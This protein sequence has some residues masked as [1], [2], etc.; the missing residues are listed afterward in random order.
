MQDHTANLT[1]LLS[2]K[3][4]AVVGG[5]AWCAAII[6]AA[7]QI[8]FEGTITPVHPKAS[9]VAGLPALRSVAEIAHPI[10]AAF[11]GVNRHATIEVVGQLRAA[12]AGG[13]ICFASGFA[14]AQ[15]EDAQGSSLQA[16]LLTAAGDMPILGPNCYGFVNALDGAAI[17]PDQHGLQACDRGVAILTQ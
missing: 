11:I 17:W 8:G 3:T 12:G 9:E 14:E 10:D 2:P 15:A 1:R 7:R 5:G 16:E 13:A 4:L 6:D